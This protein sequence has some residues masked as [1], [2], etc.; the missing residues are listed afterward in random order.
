MKS[1]KKSSKLKLGSLLLGSLLCGTSVLTACGGD[2]A[3][4]GGAKG[5]FNNETDPLVFSTQQPDGVFNPFFATSGPDTSIIG[6]TQIGMLT[7]DSKG[8]HAY[9]ENEACV[10]LDYQSVDN[11]LVQDEGLQTT[12]YFVLKNN[13]KFSD[14]KPLTMKDVLFNLYVYLDPVYTGSST[15]YSTDIV[16]LQ[17]YR[18]Q[19][20]TTE[21]QDAFTAQFQVAAQARIDALKDASKWIFEEQDNLLMTSAEFKTHLTNY[22]AANTSTTTYQNI[23]ADYDKACELFT[24]ELNTDYTNS[25]DSYED[26]KFT[27]DED[28]VHSNLFTTDVE[29][30]LYNEGVITWNK[31]EG[32]LEASSGTLEELKTYTK[33]QAIELVY[34]RQIPS[35]IEEVVSY[36]NTAVTL[37]EYL[38]NAEM[39]KHFA[40]MDRKFKNISGIKFANKDGEVT[41]NGKIYGVP[42]YNEDG[43]VATGNEVLSITINNVDPK[44]KWNFSFNVAPMHYYSD[45]EHIAAF[46]YES[47]FGVEYGSQTFMNEVLNSS[48]KVGV[49]MGAGP[50][51]ASKSSGGITG[52]EK[53]TFNDGG[54]IY[55]ERNP[56]FVLGAPKI[57]KIRYKVVPTARMLDALK[58]NEIDYGEPNAKPQTKSDVN[59][60]KNEGVPVDAKSVTTSGYGYIG[61]N[62]GKVPEIK[63]R[64]AIMHAIDTMETVRYYGTEASP[65]YRSMSKESWAYPK[66]TTSY[67]PYI[68]GKVPADL[69]VVNPD[70]ADFV[71]AE[72]LNAGDVMSVEQQ[73]RFIT[74]LVN[75]AG[76]NLTNGV[77]TNASGKTLKYTFTIAGQ[78][79]DHPAWNA[80]SQAGEFLNKIGFQITTKTDNNAL[81]KLATG[82]L[83]VW[84]AAWTATIDPDMYQVYHKESKASSVKNWG[85]TEILLNAG[86]K[87]DVEN[88][89]LDELAELIEAGR[90][91]LDQPTR[92]TIY[93]Q[94]LDKVMELAVELPTY[95][96]DDM[97]AYNTYKI[98][99]STFNSGDTLTA[100]KG[101]VSDIHQVSLN[102]TK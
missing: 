36:W 48:D 72:G 49:P 75:D 34:N 100:Y 45:A 61:V 97:F 81:Q 53:G 25:M 66:G 93:R 86:G 95:Q 13:V 29:V 31:K 8:N 20:T 15:I 76:Y 35:K 30:F 64:Q 2:P 67:Y 21:E 46:D 50:Y 5:D 74:Q 60:M 96:R 52:I 80:M 56:H 63:V 10:T 32:Q 16:G 17:E 28:V 84:A 83:E 43:S 94:A 54:L 24:K 22:A 98:D 42:T 59:K 7:N 57:N 47:N 73:Q 68:G 91:T 101:L 78:E 23:V 1:Y 3:T 11:G 82:S 18:T 77:F 27:D 41:V 19:A 69:S 62:A 14:G 4:G 40:G 89:I 90:E 38:V 39:E 6:M 71:E 85:Y 102:T 55:F 92:I 33:E 65:I 12:Y 58:N 26:I 99:V 70:Y 51:A 87:Y 44:A 79:Q 37:N 9:G 88:G